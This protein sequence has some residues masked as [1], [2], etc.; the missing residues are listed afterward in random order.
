MFQAQNRVPERK[1]FEKMDMLHNETALQHVPATFS[2]ACAD[3]T[4]LLSRLI[5]ILPD[6]LQDHEFTM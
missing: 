2:L 5:I 3:Q 1:V 4:V 6:Y